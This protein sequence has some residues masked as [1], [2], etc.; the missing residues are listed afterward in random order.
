MLVLFGI[1]IAGC[2]LPAS[3]GGNRPVAT[4]LAQD[5][6]TQSAQQTA[7][8]Q[9]LDLAPPVDDTGKTAI[10]IPAENSLAAHFPCILICFA[11]LHIKVKVGTTITWIN[12][13]HWGLTIAAVAGENLDT[14]YLHPADQVFS[15]GMSQ[16]LTNGQTFTYK[17]TTEAYNANP[18]H[19][20]FYYDE[21]NPGNFGELTI[22]A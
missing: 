22:V 20:L 9:E 21:I 19:R 5:Q 15:S 2:A 17:V 13:T 6:A 16:P 11:P 12:R 7:F 14:R 1:A 4:A 8:A 3:S 18:D 10:T